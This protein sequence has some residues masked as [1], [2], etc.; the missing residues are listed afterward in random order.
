[1]P[2]LSHRGEATC[3][4][5]QVKAGHVAPLVPRVRAGRWLW[6]VA[7]SARDVCYSVV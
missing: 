1:M 3:S 4:G 2:A 6:E 5:S 7:C